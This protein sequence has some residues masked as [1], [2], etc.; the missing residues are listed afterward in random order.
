MS[1]KGGW[2]QRRV[3][4]QSAEGGGGGGGLG[5][6]WSEDEGGGGGAANYGRTKAEAVSSAGSEGD[7]G[8]DAE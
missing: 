8:D 5:P 1:G 7:G 3:G 2:R 4:G 6:H